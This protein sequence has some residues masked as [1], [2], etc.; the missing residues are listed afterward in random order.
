MLAA[1]VAIVPT[2][3]Y[4]FYGI[5]LERPF[6]IGLTVA[7]TGDSGS[8][9]VHISSLSG[10][11]RERHLDRSSLTPNLRRSIGRVDFTDYPTQPGVDP[12]RHTLTI[13]NSCC[14]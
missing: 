13:Y 7:Q 6:V 12:S 2:W 1:P 9:T 11:E 8:P 14:R 4:W 5:A 3:I 10:H